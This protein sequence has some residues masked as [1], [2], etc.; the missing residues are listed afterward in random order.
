MRSFI[1]SLLFIAQL[2]RLSI[3]EAQVSIHV[4]RFEPLKHMVRSSAKNKGKNKVETFGKSLINN[5]KSKG[6]RWLPCRTPIRTDLGDENKFP[7][8]V[9]W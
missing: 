7:I 6:P 8:L 9:A 1:E 4:W 3:S 5:K 2:T